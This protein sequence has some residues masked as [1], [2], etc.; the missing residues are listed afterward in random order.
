MRSDSRRRII[1][2]GLVAM[3]VLYGERACSQEVSEKSGPSATMANRDDVKTLAELVRALQSQV[4]KLNARVMSLEANEK[5][6]VDQA[7]ALRR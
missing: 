3:T 1:L 6:A 4:E 7:Q 5:N 2:A